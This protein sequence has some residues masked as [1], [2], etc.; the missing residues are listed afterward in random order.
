TRFKLTGRVAKDLFGWPEVEGDA[1]VHGSLSF[2]VPS[3][4]AGYAEMHQ[5][6]GRLPLAA[7]IEPAIALARR[8]L[9]QDWFTTLKV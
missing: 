3:A 8:G 6:W 4:V 7:I 5:R 2:A 1:N 9:A